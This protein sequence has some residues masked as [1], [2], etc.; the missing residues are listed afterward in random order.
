MY[1]LIILGIIL[2]VVPLMFF[3]QSKMNSTVQNTTS[4]TEKEVGGLEGVFSITLTYDGTTPLPIANPFAQ[5]FSIPCSP[6]FSGSEILYLD[7][8]NGI[9]ALE[10]G[11]KEIS[12]E[13]VTA[14]GGYGWSSTN[15]TLLS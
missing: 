9:L 11:S 15:H 3:L 13:K 12:I 1:V 6:C 10:S 8:S 5:P 14:S 4:I 2:L 7:Y